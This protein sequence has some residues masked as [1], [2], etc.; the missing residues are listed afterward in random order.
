MLLTMFNVAVFGLL[1]GFSTSFPMAVALRLAIGLGNGF[2]GIAKT[3]ISELFFGGSHELK[4]GRAFLP[5]NPS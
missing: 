2:M 5:S 3:C 4:V 1:L